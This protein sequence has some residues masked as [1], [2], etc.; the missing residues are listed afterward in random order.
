[1]GSNNYPRNMIKVLFCKKNAVITANSS[2]SIGFFMHA[3]GGPFLSW[4]G[5]ES[6][7]WV[8]FDRFFVDR[9]SL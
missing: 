6:L 9:I 2:F 1:M 7:C 8:C 4:K 3:G 5:L